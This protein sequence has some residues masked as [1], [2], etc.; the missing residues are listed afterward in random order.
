MFDCGV[1]TIYSPK[2]LQAQELAQAT[3]EVVVAEA[4]KVMFGYVFG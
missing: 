4:E 1:S 3:T 2:P